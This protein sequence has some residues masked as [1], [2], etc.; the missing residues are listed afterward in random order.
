MPPLTRDQ[1]IA[2]IDLY[3]KCWTEQSPHLLGE[4]FT[5]D[6]IYVER[7]YDKNAT[8]RGLDA[9]RDYW[10]YQ[11]VGKQSDIKFRHVTDEMVRDADKPIA[12]VKWLASFDNRRENRAGATSDK[13]HKRVRFSQMAKIIFDPDSGKICYL[14]EYAQACTGPGVRWPNNFDDASTVSDA[15]LW[16]RV[17]Q[18]PIE[19]KAPAKNIVCTHCGESFP[20]K[21]QLFKHL[22][23]LEKEKQDTAIWVC[24]SIGYIES[25]DV[26]ENLERALSSMLPKEAAVEVDSLTWAVPPEFSASAVVNVASVKLSK[27]YIDGTSTDSLLILLNGGHL[28]SQGVY[29]HTAAVVDRP[30]IQEKRDFEKYESFI[31][32]NILL[33]QEDRDT[34]SSTTASLL[35]NCAGWSQAI[36]H[37]RIPLEKTKAADFC[38]PNLAKRL[39]DGARL[40]K[41]GGRSDLGHFANESEGEMKIRV[42]A[43]TMDEPF[44]QYCRI[45]VSMRQPKAGHVER[46]IALLVAYG[47][48]LL[49]DDE[50]TASAMKLLKEGNAAHQSAV[51][52]PSL[53]LLEPALT[54]YEGKAGISLCTSSAGVS[55]SMRKSLD[56]IECAII[57]MTENKRDE[58]AQWVADLMK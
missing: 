18:D 40:L 20:S 21:S 12:V 39:R 25:T 6:A 1:V 38:D 51:L 17:R 47:Q 31:H 44:H 54:K 9:I 48:N 13:T 22:R 16:S 29:I 15:E 49:N 26:T 37:K 55:Q 41:D 35:K 27:R 30:C 34:S 24:L 5:A 45:S 4:L 50:L 7:C 14:E 32:W 33:G 36:G 58:L 23:A 11:I 52:F 8:F 56:E 46:I 3:G 43:R 57:R 28:H 2:A 19:P 53:C 42:R 10:K